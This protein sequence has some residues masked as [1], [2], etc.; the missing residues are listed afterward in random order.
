MLELEVFIYNRPINRLLT[1]VTTNSL[2]TLELLA[3]DGLSTGAVATGKV[4]TLEHEVG[5]D[6]VE[7]GALV[8]ET[9]Y[10]SGELTEVARR[11]GYHV[12]VKLEG[13]AARG[14]VVDS[15]IELGA[16][17][18]DGVRGRSVGIHNVSIASVAHSV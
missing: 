10:T 2:L 11:L 8:A 6:T 16:S 17:R 7:A 5:D 12:V 9:V 3:V 18:H 4:T 14:L 15:D 13:D 1:W